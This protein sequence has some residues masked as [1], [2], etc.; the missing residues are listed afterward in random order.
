M[1]D[2]W[3]LDHGQD[4]EAGYE[5]ASRGPDEGEGED[6][7]TRY[8]LTALGAAALARAGA[9]AG[10]GPCAASAGPSPE[11][12]PPRRERRLPRAPRARTTPLF[13]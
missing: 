8:A 11:P 1:A 2:D 6:E 4:D 12:V 13:G 3:L 9:F 7:G 10:F 5:D